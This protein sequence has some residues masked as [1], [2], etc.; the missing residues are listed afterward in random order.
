[1]S[2]I[3]QHLQRGNTAQMLHVRTQRP[4]KEDEA[5]TEILVHRYNHG[6]ILPDVR[7]APPSDEEP[8]GGK[9]IH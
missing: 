8:P 5:N 9:N 4:W 2:E 3:S 6:L 1:M 7:P